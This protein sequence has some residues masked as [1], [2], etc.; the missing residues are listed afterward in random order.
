ML[1]LV[2]IGVREMDG[3]IAAVRF[4]RDAVAVGV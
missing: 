1:G 2:A 4:A 3:L